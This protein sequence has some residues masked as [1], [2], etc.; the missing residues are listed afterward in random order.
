MKVFGQCQCLYDCL[1]GLMH[2]TWPGFHRSKQIST[3][4]LIIHLLPDLRY[5]GVSRPASPSQFTGQYS[6][7]RGVVLL[8]KGLQQERRDLR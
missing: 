6:E 5:T 3:S 7:R 4:G 2:F 8:L 1:L